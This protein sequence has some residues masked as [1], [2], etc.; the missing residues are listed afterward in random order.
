MDKLNEIL[1]IITEHKIP[2]VDSWNPDHCATLNIIIHKDGQWRHDGS[3]IS[4]IKMVQL[5]ASILKRE[6]N[7]H[8]LVTPVEKVLINVE[9]TPF[10]VISAEII[11]G[12]WFLTN[13]LNEVVELTTNLNLSIAEKEYPTVLWRRNL[14]ARLNQNVMYQ[15]QTYALEHGHEKNGQLMLRS[16][17]QNIVIGEL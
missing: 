10:V 14:E 17:N 9:A 7:D 2:P 6:G 11:E 4:R 1:K 12:R 8:F 5:F 15:L 16:G 13:N 3:I